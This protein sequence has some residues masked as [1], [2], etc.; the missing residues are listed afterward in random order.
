MYLLCQCCCDQ[1]GEQYAR[2]F[3]AAD[4]A[5][6]GRLVCSFAPSLGPLRVLRYYFWGRVLTVAC[7]G[8]GGTAR[9]ASACGAQ[10]TSL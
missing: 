9:A 3:E 6:V 2:E 5:S 10:L 1:S 4:A 7:T 8:G